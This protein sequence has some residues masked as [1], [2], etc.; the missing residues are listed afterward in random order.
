VLNKRY[1]KGERFSLDAIDFSQV[2][3]AHQEL[4]LE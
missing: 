1:L 4:A 3:G 2:R